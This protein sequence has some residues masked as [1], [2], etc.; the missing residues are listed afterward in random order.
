MPHKD[1]A[2]FIAW[3]ERN[4][5]K[6][7]EQANARQKKFWT[8]HERPKSPPFDFAE[9]RR[10][11][12]ELKVLGVHLL[13]V[14]ELKHGFTVV[15]KLFQSSKSCVDCA[16]TKRLMILDTVTVPFSSIVLRFPFEPLHE[17]SGNREAI[18]AKFKYEHCEHLRFDD[19]AVAR[20]LAYDFRF[21]CDCDFTH[22]RRLTLDSFQMDVAFC[23]DCWSRHAADNFNFDY[24]PRCMCK[25]LDSKKDFARLPLHS[26]WSGEGFC[27]FCAQSIEEVH[28]RIRQ[29]EF[30][31]WRSGQREAK[32][33]KV[34]LE[35]NKNPFEKDWSLEN[36]FDKFKQGQR[37]GLQI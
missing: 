24:C 25:L 33:F 12:H 22:K 29:R 21:Q 36:E 7:R 20:G 2:A 8:T 10:R 6:I 26:Q 9:N 31:K 27:R 19:I 34:A 11:I 4:R 1:K 13:I 28:F 23:R 35:I 15:P 16:V 3:R 32:A 14:G 30:E 17:K 5:E 37:D 18:Q